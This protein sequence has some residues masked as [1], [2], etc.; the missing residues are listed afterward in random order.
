MVCCFTRSQLFRSVIPC[1]SVWETW[2]VK[3][4]GRNNVKYL[5]SKTFLNG[6]YNIKY[7]RNSW[8]ILKPFV[9]KSDPLTKY[10]SC[11]S[12]SDGGHDSES[13]SEGMEDYLEPSSTPGGKESVHDIL[14]PNHDDPV[15]QRLISASSV[16]EVL[17]VIK[18]NEARIKPIHLVHSVLSLWDL[19]LSSIMLCEKPY[20]GGPSHIV[21]ETFVMEL[22]SQDGTKRLLELLKDN[23][24]NMS[25]DELACTTLY[26]GKMGF[27]DIDISDVSCSQ[28]LN[29]VVRKFY[30]VSENKLHTFSLPS[31]SRLVAGM[32]FWRHAKPVVFQDSSF[33][34]PVQNRVLQCLDSCCSAEDFRLITIC[35]AHIR[36]M[37]ELSA[38]HKY[39]KI[40][41]DLISQNIFGPTELRPVLRA[42]AFLNLPHWSHLNIDLMRTLLLLLQNKVK[43][44]KPSDVVLLNHLL[45]SQL[46]PS[47][48][49]GEVQ[50]VATGLLKE[51]NHEVPVIELL[52]CLIQWVPPSNKKYFEDTVLEFICSSLSPRLLPVTFSVLRNLK[53]SNVTLCDAFWSRTL[54][55]IRAKPSMQI[56]IRL[57]RF[58][59]WY[60]H[61]NNN[62]AGTY[63]HHGFEMSI[64]EMLLHNIPKWDNPSYV[65]RGSSFIIAYSKRSSVDSILDITNRL[66]G[67]I[68][69]YNAN[70]CFMVSHGMRIAIGANRNSHKNNKNVSWLWSQL[71][72]KLDYWSEEQLKKPNI[73]LREVNQLMK[74][75]IERKAFNEKGSVIQDHIAKSYD[76]L[77][78]VHQIGADPLTGR[79]S[80]LSSRSI[81]DNCSIMIG[82]GWLFPEVVESM[83]KYVIQNGSNMTGETIDRVVQLIFLLNHWPTDGP[84]FY[85]AVAQVLDRDKERISGLNLI[86]LSLG[87]CLFNYLPKSL[88]H[89][90]FAVDFLEKIDDEIKY[91]YAKA[92]YPLRV[93]HSLM[94]LNR[95]VCLGYPEAD[96]PWFHA[97]YCQGIISMEPS[98]RTHVHE[99]M[100][101]ALLELVGGRRELIQET[102]YTPYFHKIDF[103]LVFDEFKR[104]I[105]PQSIT[106]KDVLER[107]LTRV[108]VIIR[109]DENYCRH[110]DKPGPI[111]KG[112]PLLHERHL[113]LL[114][115][116]VVG[117]PVHFW[118]SL[119]M[120]SHE[121]RVKHMTGR[122][123]GQNTGIRSTVT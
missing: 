96:I 27:S 32:R 103:L 114:G 29:S 28:L 17:N 54:D 93:R 122:I 111:L 115:Y 82:C 44:L 46:E 90:I 77:F 99:S 36:P 89:Y 107:K 9:N 33:H 60:M 69:E 4:C 14:R 112:L 16:E 8:K 48:L 40:T 57:L 19:Q 56:G 34:S 20:I 26:L 12:L 37:I 121:A 108:A 105:K 74:A 76:N 102:A 116:E 35:L 3:G 84:L 92:F 120:G 118:E 2:Q 98:A 25:P 123:F 30:S 104:P 22:L 94:E 113:Q 65:A 75:Y 38:L 71:A 119:Q 67:L 78:K 81:R 64:S 31:L 45:Q 68:P 87:L 79:V 62:L 72:R 50:E 70:D 53:T 80:G 91:C 39:K 52:S 109:K 95:A 100:F 63:H 88:I 58:C 7:C 66:I 73:S 5:S 11:R 6:I 55:F 10:L 13:D 49:I 23:C 106:Q 59:H 15:I 85:E 51:K 101:A 110:V 83:C 86:Q 117:I 97:N 42:A 43:E 21:S 24:E 18:E 1:K 47:A 61:F 41:A